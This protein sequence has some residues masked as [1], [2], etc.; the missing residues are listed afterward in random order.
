MSD[1]AQPV[2]S[3][4]SM[5]EARRNAPIGL[6][7]IHLPSQLVERVEAVSPIWLREH[8]RH[9]VGEAARASAVIAYLVTLGLAA[10]CTPE[11]Q[12]EAVSA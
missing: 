9:E 4:A 5:D 12:P 8:E 3:I 2:P 6:P 11:R 7:P 1:T 10:L